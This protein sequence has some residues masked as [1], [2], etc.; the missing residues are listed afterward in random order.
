VAQNAN[1]CLELGVGWVKSDPGELLMNKQTMCSGVGVLGF[2]VTLLLSVQAKA[3]LMGSTL[4]W[5]YFASGGPYIGGDGTPE[6]GTFVVNGGI[7]DTFMPGIT[8]AYFNILAD[9]D[10]ITFDYSVS[11]VVGMWDP[12][13]ISLPPTIHN[14]IA[15]NLES[16]PAFLAVTVNPATNMIGFDASRISFTPNQIQVDWQNLAFDTSTIVKL[17]VITVPAPTAA[18]I[19]TV[20]IALMNVR[21][22]RRCDGSL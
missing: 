22:R 14:G 19:L 15:I 21:R 1:F 20:G 7:G 10:S 16:G 3:N 13:Q 9:A 5:Q 18:P 12:S 6:G 4:S 2:S 17:D 8:V 11:T